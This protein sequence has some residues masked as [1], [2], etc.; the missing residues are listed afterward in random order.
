MIDLCGY[1]HG[2]T[3]ASNGRGCRLHGCN[4]RGRLRRRCRD[5]P[6]P[7]AGAEFRVVVEFRA[8]LAAEHNFPFV[9]FLNVVDKISERYV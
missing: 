1:W 3:D 8:A 5:D 4:W 2:L 9:R 7:A 6:L